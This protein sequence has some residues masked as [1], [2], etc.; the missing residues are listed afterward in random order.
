MG[1]QIVNPVEDAI[2]SV[3]VRIIEEKDVHWITCRP[4][5]VCHQLRPKRG[6]ADPDQEHM[7]ETF[8]I[9]GRDFSGVNIGGEFFNAVDGLFNFG[10][11]FGSWRKRRTPE[12]VM[13]DHPFFS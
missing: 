8:S 7:L 5:R 11:K 13:T 12:P 9:F 10:A 6:A 4:K 3:R 1:E 2:E